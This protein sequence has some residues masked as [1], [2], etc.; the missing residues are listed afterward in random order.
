[1]NTNGKASANILRSSVAALLFLCVVIPLSSAINLTGRHLKFPP[2]ENNTA[3]GNE[4]TASVSAPATRRD[5]T[6]TFADRV[7]YQRAVEEV[8]WRHRIWPEAN[9]GPKL[10]LDNLMSQA[11]IEKKVED[12]LRNSRALEEQAVS[13]SQLQ[14]EMD[15]MAQ[16][17]RQPQVLREL[18]AALENDP[19]VIAECLAR[20]TLSERLV[21]NLLR[22]Q[23]FPNELMRELLRDLKGRAPR[24][25][26][27]A[28]AR[29]EMPKLRMTSGTE[30]V[31]PAIVESENEFS[32]V[33]GAAANATTA[34]TSSG[35]CTD[36]SWTATSTTNAPPPRING[37]TTL[38]TGSEMIVW[39][40]NEGS[41]PV[42]T[43]G[44]YN[45]ST[46]TWTATSTIDAPST[47]FHTAVWTGSEMIIWGGTSAT[48]PS[49]NR[50]G[51]YNPTTDTWTAT[52]T[53]NAPS[54]RGQHAA[55]WTGSE[56]IVWGGRDNSNGNL[57]NTGGRYNPTTDTWTATSI[58]NAPSGRVRA[59]AVWT[60]SEMIIW[61][62]YDG[63]QFFNTGGR[64]NPITDAWTATSTTNAS[65]RDNHTAVWTGSEMIIWG[66][67]NS[68]GLVNPGGRY[69]SAT[70]TWTATS[71][72]NAPSARVYHTAIWTGS[73]MIVWG[74]SPS[75]LMLTN[76]G[77]RYNPTTDTWT[78]TSTTNAPSA[79]GDHRAVWT[80]REMIVWGGVGGSYLNTGGKYCAAAPPVGQ[81]LNVSTRMQ[82]LTAN[83]ALIAGFI[84]GGTGSKDVL[85]RALGPTLQNFG[86]N[87]FVADPT[88]DLRDSNQVQIAFNDNWKD[89]QQSAIN[90][91]G[92]APPSD[93][94]S[95]IRRTFTPGNYTATVRGKNNTTGIGLVEVYDLD[96]A[97]AIT[98]T[99]ISTRG[100][101]NTG[102]NLMI[103][104]FISGNGIVRVIMRALG[105]TL[106]QFGVPNVL[107][108]PVLDVRD[109]QGN[110]LVTNDNWKDSQQAEIQ[111]SGKAPPNDKE[112]A[113]IIM[114]PAG[115]TTAIVSGKNNTTGN[116]LVEAY[117]LPP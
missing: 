87:G 41:G 4:T 24:K 103:G 69:N 10:P 3:F 113:I 20:P 38:W 71:I 8:Y 80:G 58:T 15:R 106:T 81:L 63:L 18:F 114:R 83:N 94:E 66:G 30:Y 76:T 33:N 22:N 19:F 60:G 16:Q 12:Y 65:A 51:R 89:T 27:D 78:A 86:I 43:G 104:G 37:Y 95:A 101:V 36:D 59:T 116:A 48:G 108:D 117:V 100:F 44:R 77:G 98:L 68:G 79:R 97:G 5:R 73:E 111:A 93:A 23:R 1:M 6:L 40:G 82:V 53:T 92:K 32:G 67:D 90:A 57:F 84:I 9:A 42:N 49:V 17:T 88:L 54:A 55:V 7:A 91:T 61:G 62:G 110:S 25:S 26:L 31:L 85:L 45:P 72:T 109:A 46:D 14:A 2:P 74:G 64:Y 39:G 107:A 115:N 96:Q 105:P 21:T 34:P 13:A 11:Q 99:N 56:M 47:E 112:S 102:N 35:G 75:F 50:G 29:D 70:D 28:T 52:S